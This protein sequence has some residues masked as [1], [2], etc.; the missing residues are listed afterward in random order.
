M[1]TKEELET[2]AADLQM[3]LAKLQAANS[4]SQSE[5]WAEKSIENTA[6]VEKPT[7]GA[8]KDQPTDEAKKLVEDLTGILNA[9]PTTKTALL[10]L[11]VF[12]I[13]YLLGRSR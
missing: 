1:A 8:H 4:V 9:H 12:G 2:E 5:E 13:G 7:E 11:G 6:P 3:E 10:L